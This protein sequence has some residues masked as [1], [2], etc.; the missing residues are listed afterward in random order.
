M[1]Q[2]KENT[3]WDLKVADKIRTTELVTEKE[4]QILRNDLDPGSIYLK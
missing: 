1:E 4:L 3:G 2:A